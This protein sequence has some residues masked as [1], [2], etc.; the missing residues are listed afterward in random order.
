MVRKILDGKSRLSLAKHKEVSFRQYF[1][2]RKVHKKDFVLIMIHVEWIEE[3]EVGGIVFA[4]GFC[5]LTNIP[6]VSEKDCIMYSLEKQLQKV[7]VEHT[8][9]KQRYSYSILS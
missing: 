5:A 7:V 1:F 8:P 3:L 9:Q 6:V 2:S 4:F